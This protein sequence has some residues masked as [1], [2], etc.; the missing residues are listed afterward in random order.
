M[1]LNAYT[2]WDNEIEIERGVWV[3][4]RPLGGAAEPFA[5]RLREAWAVLKG[6]RHTIV[7]P[8]QEPKE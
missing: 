8:G 7:F 6:H 3:P 5:W 1:K 2:L 4:A